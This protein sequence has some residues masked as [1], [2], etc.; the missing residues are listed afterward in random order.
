[1]LFLNVRRGSPEVRRGS[2]DPVRRGAPDPAAR[3]TAGLHMRQETFGRLLWLGQ[4][5]GRNKVSI[6]HFEA[7]ASGNGVSFLF[8]AVVMLVTVAV[9]F[10]SSTISTSLFS[11]FSTMILFSTAVAG[12]LCI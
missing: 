4:E 10:F 1:M 2:P 12:G 5:T 7:G 11:L 6:D 9:L 8:S 3:L